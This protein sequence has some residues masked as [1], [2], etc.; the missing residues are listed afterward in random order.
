MMKGDR[1]TPEVVGL[2]LLFLGITALTV[3]GFATKTW[4]PPVASD[5]GVGVDG[6]IRYLTLSTGAVLVIGTTAMV[7]FLWRY[8]RGRPT[9]SPATDPKAERWWSLVPVLG[10]ALIAEAGVLVKGFP[11]WKRIHGTPPPNA[12]VVEI[13]AQQFEW[14]ARYPGP[15]GTLGR[16]RP[17]LVETTTNPIGLD[18]EDLSGRDDIV[19]R[20]ALHL[21]AGRPVALRLRSQDVLHSFSVPAFRVKQ[22]VVPGIVGRITFTPTLA[23]RYE[24]ACAELCGMG[25]YRMSGSV[26]VHAPADYQAWL[27]AQAGLVR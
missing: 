14:Y 8:G 16:V 26:L 25:H 17:Q 3:V 12:I 5:H 23:G 11:V 27:D 4:M 18:R 9:P 22:D 20:N 2:A 15:D 1:Q 13:T 19:S 24:I 6:V 7:W 10:M 21:P